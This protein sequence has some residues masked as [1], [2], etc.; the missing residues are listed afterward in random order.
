MERNSHPPW[1]THRLKKED[2]F[3]KQGGVPYECRWKWKGGRPRRSSQAKQVGFSSIFGG[4]EQEF[5]PLLM[6]R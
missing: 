4:F 2:F 3:L 1:I 6:K 5:T